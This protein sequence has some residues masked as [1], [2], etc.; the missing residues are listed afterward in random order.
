MSLNRFEVFWKISL[1]FLCILEHIVSVLDIGEIWF[2]N[3]L[4][5]LQTAGTSHVS[6]YMLWN[7]LRWAQA[8][9]HASWNY[10]HILTH[11]GFPQKTDR[12]NCS[13][14]VDS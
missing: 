11:I 10:G 4:H 12:L 7:I 14:R 6:S 8:A 5:K 2:Q 1:H 9:P 3:P 13:P